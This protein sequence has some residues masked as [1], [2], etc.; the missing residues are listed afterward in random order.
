MPTSTERSSSWKM[1]SGTPEFFRLLAR[2]TMALERE[3]GVA[4][5][6]SRAGDGFCAP[7]KHRGVAE[8]CLGGAGDTH[9]QAGQAGELAV[10]RG[11]V[12]VAHGE[13]LLRGVGRGSRG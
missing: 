11:E 9:P 2:A 5:A 12:V 1:S 13:M 7:P 6:S 3:R 10:E 8:R 4:A